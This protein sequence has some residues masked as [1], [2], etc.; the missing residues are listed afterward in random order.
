[1]YDAETGFFLPGNHSMAVVVPGSY[2]Q[3]DFV[4]GDVIDKLGPAGSN[5]FYT[6]QGRLISADNDGTTAP[7][8]NPPFYGFTVAVGA[9]SGNDD[10][11]FKKASDTSKMSVKINGA[12]VDQISFGAGSGIAITKLAG[13]GNNGSD[14]IRVTGLSIPATLKGGNGPDILVGGDGDDA[15]QGD[16][17]R[18]IMIGGEGKDVIH[19]N[20][21]DDILIGG[22]TVYDNNLAALDSILAEWTS[23]LSFTDRVNRLK[24]TSASGAAYRLIANAANGWAKTVFDDEDQDTLYGDDGYDWMLANTDADGGSANDLIY[25]SSSITDID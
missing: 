15:I 1:V 14:T 12:E 8:S 17:D 20:S 13:Y 3:I 5:I 19:G 2:F 7:S 24:S 16:A 10:V 6:P 21:H 23:N 4:C 22:S 25:S 18:D 11:Q 9:G